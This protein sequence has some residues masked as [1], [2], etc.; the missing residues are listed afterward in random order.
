MRRLGPD[1][2]PPAFSGTDLRSNRKNPKGSASTASAIDWRNL[3]RWVQRFSQGKVLVVG[4]LMLDHY[5]WG[6]VSRISPEAPV[7]VVHVEKESLCLGGAANVYHNLRS[8]GGHAEICGI[9][10]PD[11]NGRALLDQL[12]I[13]R[14]GREGVVVDS[15][16]PTTRKTRVLAHS[17]Q[18]VRYDVEQREEISRSANRRILKFIEGRLSQISCL[19]VSD[20]AKGVITAPLM[21][22][23]GRLARK[24]SIPIVV[25]PKVEHLPFYAGVTIITP[26]HGEAERGVGF[27]ARDRGSIH[28]VGHL[29]RQ[30]LGCEAVLITQ[31]EQGMSLCESNGSSWHIPAVA[32]EVYDVTGAGDTVVSTLALAMSVGASMR[33]GAVLANHA[34][35]IVVGMVGT[36]CVTQA[37]LKEA[38]RNAS[39]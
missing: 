23:L 36:A 4:D 11:E 29:L 5:I 35:G 22:E 9:V 24:K 30:K 7:P 6:T 17:Q 33:D 28:D 3:E 1:F 13:G 14:R 38:L 20:Y 10:G 34:A 12:G 37:Q 2:M 16:R 8:L 27:S 25:D 18:V 15:N 39:R 32:R 26:N 31:G 21:A 19:V